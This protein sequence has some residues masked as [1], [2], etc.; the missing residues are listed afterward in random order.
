MFTRLGG[1]WRTEKGAM[2]R[3]S[4]NVFL[5][6]KYTSIWFDLPLGICSYLILNAL[7]IWHRYCIDV[8][9]F[10]PYF[11]WPCS[12]QWRPWFK[13]IKFQSA[14][15]WYDINESSVGRLP[16]KRAIH[17]KDALSLISKENTWLVR[18]C[19]APLRLSQT[20]FDKY[21]QWRAETQT[22]SS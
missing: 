2:K 19:T 17:E 21:W 22:D 5:L 16:P 9:N 18:V 3:L 14:N 13:N 15:Y 4:T 20:I 10:A 7:C 6:N 12:K 1:A 8:L 11:S